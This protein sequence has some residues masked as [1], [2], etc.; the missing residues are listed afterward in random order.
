MKTLPRVPSRKT[1]FFFMVS[2]QVNLNHE[3]RPYGKIEKSTKSLHP[4]VYQG[5]RWVGLMKEKN[6]KKTRDTA[7]LRSPKWT[8][9]FYVLISHSNWK[10]VFST[11]KATIILVKKDLE[12]TLLHAQQE[13]WVSEYLYCIY[14]IIYEYLVWPI[15][16]ISVY[17]W[18]VHWWKWDIFGII[19]HTV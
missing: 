7:S 15:S 4:T 8:V 6:A 3:R 18:T 1:F 19:C 17:S 13:L 11:G 9:N 12:Y 2:E 5:P 16:W 10:E 14:C